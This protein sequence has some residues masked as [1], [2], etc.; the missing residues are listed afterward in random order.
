MSSRRVRP[1]RYQGFRTGRVARGSLSL[2]VLTAAA[3]VPVV[4]GTASAAIGGHAAV[5]GLTGDFN[6]DGHVDLV[7]SAPDATVDGA[8]GA[9]VVTIAY[10][11]AAGAGVEQG[12]RATVS[13][14]TDGVGGEADAGDHFGFSV[15]VADFDEDG[16]DDL[17]AGVPGEDVEGEAEAGTVQILWGSAAGVSGS[18]TLT[19]PATENHQAHGRT[20]AAGD[21]NGDGRA[22][23]ATGNTSPEMWLYSGGFT[24]EG[25]HGG[26]YPLG[27]LYTWNGEVTALTAGDVTGDGA[28]DLLVNHRSLYRSGAGESGVLGL[29]RASYDMAARGYAST[30]GDFDGDGYTDVVTARAN[31]G[32]EITYIPG[33][34]TSATD[35]TWTGNYDRSYTMNQAQFDT[36]GEDRIYDR[37]GAGL[38]AGDINGDGYDDLIAGD[39]NEDADGGAV[40]DAGHVVVLYGARNGLVTTGRQVFDQGF[41]GIPGDNETGD[42]FGAQLLLEDLNGDGRKDLTIAAPGEDGGSGALTTLLGTGTGLTTAGVRTLD[43]ASYGLSAAGQPRLGSGLQGHPPITPQPAPPAG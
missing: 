23:L 17:A 13:Q 4:T 3:L 5:S 28:D 39:P 27:Y 6:G 29:D 8:E 19:D 14:N 43:T 22:D 7:A 32:G 21:F 35:P 33:G 37:Y 26:T 16:Y 1:A 18:A 2:A 34:P 38:A 11:S 15:A 9:G 41:E 36:P 12:D 25:G 40:A 10:G 42:E 31:K 24:R 30:F 20:L